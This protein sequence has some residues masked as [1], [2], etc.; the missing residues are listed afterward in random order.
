MWTVNKCAA[1]YLPMYPPLTAWKK[2]T[3]GLINMFYYILISHLILFIY[4]TIV[5]IHPFHNQH[6]KR[7]YILLW[8]N[9]AKFNL[10]HGHG[11]HVRFFTG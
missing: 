11:Y 10:E 3:P 1:H 9:S 6:Q 5:F 2:S 7:S 8:M 4:V